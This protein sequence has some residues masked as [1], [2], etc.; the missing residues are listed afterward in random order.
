MKR[1]WAPPAGRKGTVCVFTGRGECIEKYFETVRDLRARGFAVAMIGWRGQGHSARQLSDYRKGYV[2][3]FRDYEADVAAFV[4]Y[5][6]V[7]RIDGHKRTIGSSAAFIKAYDQIMTPDIVAAVK[8]QKYEDLFVNYQGVMF[9]DGE[10][11]IN[12]ICLDRQCK[13]TVPK[14]VTIQHTDT[15]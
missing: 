9:G 4:R 14:V 15:N 3:S 2:R 7:V 1:R 6:I 13:H 5:P 11:W 12:G 8:G 10:V